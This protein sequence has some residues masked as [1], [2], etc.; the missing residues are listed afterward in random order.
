M[1]G[2]D[3]SAPRTAVGGSG[4]GGQQGG[5]DKY[6]ELHAGGVGGVWGHTLNKFT[7][8]IVDLCFGNEVVLRSPYLLVEKKPGGGEGCL[9]IGRRVKTDDGLLSCPSFIPRTG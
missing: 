6:Q 2:V 7:A 4:G 9:L 5:G 1:E 8:I 3:A